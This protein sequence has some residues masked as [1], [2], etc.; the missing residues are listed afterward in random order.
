MANREPSHSSYT[1]VF[2]GFGA[3]EGSV[4]D[5]RAY[6]RLEVVC[7]QHARHAKEVGMSI[8]ANKAL[9]Q[10]IATALTQHNLD[11][12]DDLF[13][14]DY[15]E[16]DPAPGQGPGLAGLKAWLATYFAAFPD[17]RWTVEEQLGEGDRVVSRSTWQGTHQG[18]FMGIPPTGRQVTV[19]AWTM[20]RVADGKIAESRI[21]MD[22]VGLLQQVGAI[23]T[24]EQGDA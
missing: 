14:V 21:I 3:L 20:D 24:P 9:Q 10:R 22:L 15:V 18:P 16:L 8:E 23:P 6:W 19:A 13:H 1:G 4:I 17:V 12:L 11:V 7:C 2:N 5:G